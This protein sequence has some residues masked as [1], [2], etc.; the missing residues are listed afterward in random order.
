MVKCQNF[1][2]QAP[3]CPR[4]RSLMTLMTPARFWLLQ[5]LQ[6]WGLTCKCKTYFM[7]YFQSHINRFFSLSSGC[8]LSAIQDIVHYQAHIVCLPFCFTSPYH[9]FSLS[10]SIKRI[11]FNSLVKPNVNEKGE[12]QMETI[13]TS[14]ALQIAGRAGRSASFDNNAD[15]P[16]ELLLGHYIKLHLLPPVAGS[17]PSLKREKLQQCTET[18]SPSSKKYSVTLSILQR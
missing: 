6:A 4:Q 2:L 11:I 9:P 18:I 5:M 12:K 13:S 15:N 16:F 1:D 3:N 10:R 8:M 7:K 17:P 14:Q